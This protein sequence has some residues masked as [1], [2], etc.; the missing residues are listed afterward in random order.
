MFEVRESV[1][2]EARGVTPVVS[3]L[4][5][6]SDEESAVSFA[7]NLINSYI[8]IYA[9][10]FTQDDVSKLI[11]VSEELIWSSVNGFADGRDKPDIEELERLEYLRLKE[12]FEGVVEEPE[13]EPEEV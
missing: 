9:V 11:D 2:D 10:S 5:R 4:A 1:L 6:F 7:S 13:P 8:L 12:K 3:V